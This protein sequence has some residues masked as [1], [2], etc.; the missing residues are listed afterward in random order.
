MVPDKSREIIFYCAAGGRAQTALEQAL[1]LGYETVY[2]LG[3]ISDW[4]YEIEKE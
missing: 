1:D 4:P 3:G 2:N